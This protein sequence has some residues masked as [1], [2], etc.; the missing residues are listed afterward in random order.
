MKE[1]GIEIEKITEKVVTGT[2]IWVQEGNVT[3]GETGIEI[4]IGKFLNKAT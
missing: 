3:V 2:K 4:A 1:E